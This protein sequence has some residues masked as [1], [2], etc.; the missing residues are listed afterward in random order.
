MVRRLLLL[1]VWLTI[2]CFSFRQAKTQPPRAPGAV[3]SS[4]FKQAEALYNSP[5]ATDISDSIALHLYL[6]AI[7]RITNDGALD[8]L[9]LPSY[10]KAGILTMLH[11]QPHTAL[12]L[13]RQA[14]IARKQRPHLPD[15]LLFLPLLYSG[16][17]QYDLN[18]LDSAMWY[19]QRAE[20]LLSRHPT[21]TES[22]RL[23]NKLG[24][25]YYEMGDYRK[26][27]PYFGRALR[28]IEAREPRDINFMVNYR[29]NIASA[30]RKLGYTDSAISVYKG[31]LSF[32]INI[33]DLLHNIGVTYL[34]IGRNKEALEWLRK[35]PYG[36]TAGIPLSNHLALACLRLHQPQQAK[37][38]IDDAVRQYE[39]KG[40]QRHD[41][42]H[43]NTWWIAGDLAIEQHDPS[44][45]LRL[46]QTAILDLVRDFTDTSIYANPTSFQRLSNSFVLFDILVAKARAFSSLGSSALQHALDTYDAAL[47]LSRQLQLVYRSDESR[48]FLNN[49]VTP[50]CREAV[51]LAV[52]HLS[53]VHDSQLIERVFRWCEGNKASVWQAA[54]YSLQLESIP[55]LPQQLLKEAKVSKALLA[56]LNLQ[57]MLTHDNAI[58][59]EVDRQITDETIHLASIEQRLEQNPDFHRLLFASREITLDSIQRNLVSPDEILLSY[60]YTDS[61]LLCFYSTTDGHG[62][63]SRPLPAAFTHAIEQ[64]RGELDKGEAADGFVIRARGAELYNALVKPLLPHAPGKKHLVIIP[65]NAISYIP[66]ESLSDTSGGQIILRDFAV[67]YLYSSNFLNKRL[68]ASAPSYK[69]LAF[70][71]FAHTSGP[72]EPVLPA[73]AAE[74][75]SLKGLRLY[76]SMASKTALISRL[77]DYPIIHLATHAT[78]NDIDPLQSYIAFFERGPEGDTTGRLYEQEIYHLN[79]QHTDLILLSACE[80]GGGLLVNGEGVMSLSRAFSYAGCPAVITSLWRAEDQ[81]TSYLSSRLHHYLSKGLRVDEALQKAKLDFLDDGSIPSRLKSPAFWA[82]LV[83][84]GDYRPVAKEGLPWVWICI[85]GFLLIITVIVLYKGRGYHKP[86]GLAS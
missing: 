75:A 60:Y 39:K 21:L 26:S 5:T 15:S 16:S 28:I 81:V 63:Y 14:I 51:N 29:N 54:L 12:D 78:A 20:E 76:D 49:K 70:A 44:R 27:L 86:P 25:L 38:Y 41:F 68:S 82:P 2:F 4:L 55:G 61:L 30:L 34:D 84:I 57:I 19:Y 71:P 74:I 85:A 11:G 10:C 77:N 1:F 33:N 40:S 8:S 31:L 64:Y 35:I 79:M 42:D 65:Y 23:Y 72:Y 66:F 18:D 43:A 13:F 69:V 59:M 37:A 3:V 62:L 67:R 45:A 80:T 32:G 46:Y 83:L 56:K 36:P 48:L 52:A 73:S 58:R 17:L 7:R 9:L 24:A 47:T 6:E 22:E 50:T 53:S